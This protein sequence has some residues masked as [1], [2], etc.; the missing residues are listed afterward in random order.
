MSDLFPKENLAEEEAKP[1]AARLRPRTLEEFV[2]QEHIL[3]PGRLLRRM[4]EAGRLSNLILTGPPGCGK[5]SLAEVVAGATQSAFVALNAVTAGV[6]ELRAEVE[7]ARNRLRMQQ[8]RTILFIDELHRFN[9]AQQDALL[10][11]TEAGT[12]ILVGATVHNPY[13]SIN[14][15]LLSRSTVFELKL[16]EKEHLQK[17]LE[18]A[19][20]DAERGLGYMKVEL[21][22]PAR[23]FLLDIAGGDARR[24]LNALEIAALS[25]PMDKKGKVHINLETVQESTQRRHIAYDA[26]EDEHYQTISAF[27][28][29]LRGSDPNASLYWLAKMLVAGEDPMFIARRLVISS[30]EDVGLADPQA[31]NIATSAMV[32]LEHIGLPEGAIPLAEATI[33]I[34]TA[35]KSNSA[36]M[37]LSRAQSDLQENPVMA[38]PLHLRNLPPHRLPAGVSYRYPHDFPGGFVAQEYLPEPRDFYHPKEIGYEREIV[39][40]MEWFRKKIAEAFG[41]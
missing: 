31:L 32:A 4:L 21:D 5:T 15:T 30:A 38:V 18:R 37:A 1:L 16:L 36:Y 9:K 41:K 6:K 8:R 40:R 28:K 35:P 26:D 24:L 34:A 27:I 20:E 10:P 12:I 19:L 7:S 33:Y 29:S 11:H 17:I 23:N 39:K 3:G 14:S 25:T 13:F 22:K 2:G